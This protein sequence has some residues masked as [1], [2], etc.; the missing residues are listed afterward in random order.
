MGN[1]I[2]IKEKR[3]CVKPLRS[4]LEAIQKLK[5][6]TNQKGCRSFV[7]VVNFVSIFCPELQKLL[8]PIYEL[9]KK[10]RPFIWGDEQ[11]KAFDEIKSRLLKPPVL[12]MPDKR[13]RFLLYSDTSKYA[14]GSA[15]Y[16]V[17]NGKPKLIAYMSK[18]MPKAA[19]NYSITELEMCGL[20]INIASFAHLLK[21]VDFDAIVDHLAIMHIMKSKMEP[22]TNRIKRLLEVLS[23]Y[24]FNLYYIKGKDMILSDFLS[25]QIEDDS[26]PHEIIP[27]SFNIWEILQENYHNIVSD[28]YKVQMRAQAKAQTNAP[29]EVN[30]QPV[31]QKATPKIVKLPIKTEKEKDSKTL[32]SRIVQQ[33][34]KGIV[35]P[36]G[37]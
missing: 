23:S 9:T 20:A 10:G 7:G 13:G 36:P 2:F 15:L 34:P 3:V 33:P 25:R 31:A 37:A 26:N 17:Q 18:R 27:I 19:R 30:T 35:M 1:T 16:Q 12:S 28:T 21:R 24:S 4:R 5:P 32:L 14:T 8:K 29:T 22:A 6:P 11:Q